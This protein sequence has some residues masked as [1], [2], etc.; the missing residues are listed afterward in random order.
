M[1]IKKWQFHP[2][3]N[4]RER[5]AQELSIF[6][7]DFGRLWLVIGILALFGIVPWV[8]GPYMIYIFNT[9]GIAAIAVIGLNILIGFTGQISLGHGAFFGVGA[10]AAAILATTLNCPFYLSIP[11]A[12]VITAMVGMVFGTP[13]VRLEGSLSDDCHPGRPIHHRISVDTLGKYHQGHD[14]DYA[15]PRDVFGASCFRRYG[16]LLH[17]LCSAVRRRLDCSQSNAYPLRTGLHRHSRQ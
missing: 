9:I 16:F 7:T 3:G 14:G 8:F 1:K 17:H 5:Y 13:S 2:C 10:Y 4:Y 11:A 6:E 12:A 15:S